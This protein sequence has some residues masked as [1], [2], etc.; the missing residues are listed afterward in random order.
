MNNK[1]AYCL[2]VCLTFFMS[3][4]AHTAQLSFEDLLIAPKFKGQRIPD[5]DVKMFYYQYKCYLPNNKQSVEGEDW[6][7]L[8]E[9]KNDADYWVSFIQID[10]SVRELRRSIDTVIHATDID[11]EYD[12]I[13]AKFCD[14]YYKTER[15]VSN[16]SFIEAFKN[17]N[18]YKNQYKTGESRC[19]ISGERTQNVLACKN[20]I[21]KKNELIDKHE[22]ELESLNAE[23]EKLKESKNAHNLNM[24]E[25]EKEIKSIKEENKELTK[26]N[27]ELNTAV[28]KLENQNNKGTT[29]LRKEIE[30]LKKERNEFKRMY[31]LGKNNFEKLE[32]QHLQLV[33]ERDKYK[34]NFEDAKQEIK[35]LK[36]QLKAN[37][38]QKLADIKAIK[39]Y[40][41]YWLVGIA[42]GIAVVVL[43]CTWFANRNIGRA[44]KSGLSE[45]LDN[46]KL[47]KEGLGNKQKIDNDDMEQFKQ[48]NSELVERLL[49]DSKQ[50]IEQINQEKQT[51][52]NQIDSFRKLL[53]IKPEEIE[54]AT[55][56]SSPPP[57]KKANVIQLEFDKSEYIRLT[58]LD[59]VEFFNLKEQPY[60]YQPSDNHELSVNQCF[61]VDISNIIQANKIDEFLQALSNV[62]KKN[63]V[64]N[65]KWSD[66]NTIKQ[67]KEKF[68]IKGDSNE[69]LYNELVKYKSST[70]TQYNQPIIE[71]ITALQESHNNGLK[72]DSLQNALTKIYVLITSQLNEVNVADKNIIDNVTVDDLQSKLST[73]LNNY[74]NY[75]S[76]LEQFEC[77]LL[78]QKQDDKFN[79][80]RQKNGDLSALLV[81]FEMIKTRL[82]MTDPISVRELNQQFNHTMD[83][84]VGAVADVK[85]LIGDNSKEYHLNA[86]ITLLDA[87]RLSIKTSQTRIQSLEVIE[88]EYNEFTELLSKRAELKNNDVNNSVP[89][90]NLMLLQSLLNKLDSEHLAGNVLTDVIDW[91]NS[92]NEAYE[93]DVVNK[94]LL[95]ALKKR[96]KT[97]KI[98]YDKQQ[99]LFE[100]CST[101][102]RELTKALDVTDVIEGPEAIRIKDKLSVI[103]VYDDLTDKVKL[104]QWQACLSA[105]AIYCVNSP[106]QYVMGDL[107]KPLRD[108]YHAAMHVLAYHGV[109][110][111]LPYYNCQSTAVGERMAAFEN[112]AT[113]YQLDNSTSEQLKNYYLR[114]TA[115]NLILLAKLSLPKGAMERLLTIAH[116]EDYDTYVEQ[117]AT[118]SR[119]LIVRVPELS[120]T[121]YKLPEQQIVEGVTCYDQL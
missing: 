15:G 60:V 38:A 98:A 89:Q 42:F 95:E 82:G 55:L 74:R 68:S 72:H 88:T 73:L 16:S 63:N 103:T 49:D 101:K 91:V 66:G 111:V 37:K 99:V 5:E 1:L 62:L 69:D 120:L 105:V 53:E 104:G 119:P 4:M 28:R 64:A 116:L 121:S 97:A 10:A 90:T 115:L 44:I 11:S 96:Q 2:L 112:L 80:L 76:L 17:S 7:R 18:N 43:L 6:F 70:F 109:E 78:G 9:R 35:V 75:K 65:D 13:L 118:D 45:I 47:G 106:A 51:L 22:L 41:I 71:S 56:F 39:E 100:S 58:K 36:E 14:N 61:S 108:F 84:L 86:L 25:K 113:F 77:S 81:M 8:I 31:T 46:I 33:S 92:N 102:L 114:Q 48:E 52:L 12:K 29:E 32:G 83:R 85:S 40:V 79:A 117:F 27:G 24:Q 21:A 3:F 19:F 57:R 20:S 94:T 50:E 67:L 93:T 107:E 54:T 30:G 26:K 23:I 59:A 87:C 110:V 34:E